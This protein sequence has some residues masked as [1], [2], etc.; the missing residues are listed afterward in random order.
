MLHDAAACSL[1]LSAQFTHIHSPA[2]VHTR[3]RKPAPLVLHATPQV[4]C[5]ANQD[6]CGKF[7]VSGYPTLKI[8]RNGEVSAD[9][10]GPRQAGA[11]VVGDSCE[12]S[13]NMQA[14]LATRVCV[15]IVPSTDGIVSYMKKQASPSH[16]GEGIYRQ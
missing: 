8:F 13:R 16:K 4:D 12:S 3:N 15:C 7:G 9:Y 10:A 2:H 5:T 11:L 1:Y 14:D 6:T